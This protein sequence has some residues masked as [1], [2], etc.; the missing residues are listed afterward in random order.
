MAEQKGTTEFSGLDHAWN[1]PV[2]GG[3]MA[4]QQL[5]DFT[6]GKP[7]TALNETW[8]VTAY[9]VWDP[10][11]PIR[12]FDLTVHQTCATPEPVV[13]SKH[14]YGFLG[15]RGRDEWNGQ[16]AMLVL[17]SEGATTRATANMTR[18]R[19]CYLG[20]PV[21]NGA[22]A[23]I[24]IL[25]HPA[26]VRSPESIRVHPDMPFVSFAP[27]QAADLTISPAEPFVARYRVLVF[28]GAPDRARLDA[29]WQ[30]YARE[31]KVTIAPE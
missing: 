27:V 21:E 4:K 6:S 18:V 10:R 16:D 26:N 28:D 30:G 3:F 23:G 8:E 2:H 1:G 13:L 17:T 31:P 11:F 15:V 24:A 7:V 25:G 14:L 29:Y 12:V 9:D 5:V 20:G 22:T 19:W